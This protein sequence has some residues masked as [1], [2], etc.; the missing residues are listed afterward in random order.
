MLAVIASKQ[1]A[2]RN[3]SAMGVEKRSEEDDMKLT[4]VSFCMGIPSDSGYVQ[5]DCIVRQA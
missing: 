4:G 2:H 5:Q 1:V 3:G